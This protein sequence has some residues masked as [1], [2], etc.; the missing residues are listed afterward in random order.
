[1]IMVTISLWKRAISSDNVDILSLQ[2]TCML[3]DCMEKDCN[4]W[5]GAE[6]WSGLSEDY[7]GKKEEGVAILSENPSKRIRCLKNKK[8]YAYFACYISWQNIVIMLRIQMAI[9]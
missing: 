7:K 5:K 9:Q 8:T 3:D 2:K 1:M 4:K 6:R